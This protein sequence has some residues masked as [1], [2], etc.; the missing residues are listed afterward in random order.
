[1]LYSTCKQLNTMIALRLKHKL[2]EII[3]L[4]YFLRFLFLLVA[5]YYGNLF[6]IAVIDPKGSIY[7]SF[8]DAH[9]NYI[10]W[11]RDLYLYT[12]KFLCGVVGLSTHV[13]FPYRLTS[14]NGSYVETV[15]ECLG[16]GLF[17]FWI[18]FVVANKT[19]FKKKLTWLFLGV[20]SI[21]FINCWRITILLLAIDRRWQYNKY[22]DHHTF[23]NCIAYT[24]MLVFVLSYIKQNKTPGLLQN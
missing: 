7:S 2:D 3:D 24:L 14:D 1:M 13:T 5:L 16:I 20:F 23:F 18:A 12:S 6:Y 19:S 9:F 21:W 4:S 10:N 8:L 22:I 11:I 15:Y 17:S